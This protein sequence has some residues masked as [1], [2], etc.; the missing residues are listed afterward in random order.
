MHNFRTFVAATVAL[1]LPALAT[2]QVCPPAWSKTATYAPGDIVQY[3]GNWFR[4]LKALSASTTT[5]N[6]AYGSWELNYVRSATTLLIGTDQTFANLATAWDFAL[7]ARV[8]DDVTL[9]FYISSAKGNYSEVCS[10]QFL[11]NHGSGARINI[12]GDSAANDVIT[13]AGTNGLAVTEGHTLNSITGITVRDSNPTGPQTNGLTADSGATIGDADNMVISGFYNSVYANRNANVS[14]GPGAELTGFSNFAADA[15]GGAMIDFP[16]GTTITGSGTKTTNAALYVDYGGKIIAD[17]SDITACNF[18]GYAQHGGVLSVVQCTFLNCSVGLYSA[19]G[20]EIDSTEAHE[21][22]CGTGAW[23]EDA[24][25]IDMA[26]NTVNGYSV[27][28]IKADERGFV[29]CSDCLITNGT[30]NYDLFAVTGG[31]IQATDASY[32]TSLS[33]G[34]TD[35][36][37]ITS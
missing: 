27:N 9:T 4:A 24:G 12:T 26:L 7:N 11:L 14:I 3:G 29:N 22:S 15:T 25:T 2:A 21:T 35:G 16:Q 23:A 18:G 1:L 6:G 36:S 20:G 8:A 30:G 31:C 17:S 32:N 13:F 10:G 19:R 33:N 28:A 5:P 34:A 37:Y